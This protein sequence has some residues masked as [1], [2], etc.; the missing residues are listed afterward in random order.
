MIP[1]LDSTKEA[2]LR[3]MVKVSAKR[4][5]QAIFPARTRREG[6]PPP[7]HDMA[8]PK[9][10]FRRQA[11]QELGV[12]LGLPEPGN[13]HFHRLDGAKSL[14]RTS[15]GVDAL[16]FIRVI[17]ELFFAGARPVNVD[18]REDAAFDQATIQVQLH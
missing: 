1:A 7:R 17:N 15:Q 2:D 5:A 6:S 8:E 13:E 4:L 18:R 16:E 11:Q 3:A 9:A 14:H 10:L 12:R